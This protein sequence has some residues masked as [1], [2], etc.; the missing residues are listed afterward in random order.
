[1]EDKKVKAGSVAIGICLF[2][3]AILLVL[4]VIVFYN[5]TM[6]KNN[7]QAKVSELETTIEENGIQSSIS[8]NNS[9]DK[10]KIPSVYTAD[11]KNLSKGV[12]YDLGIGD[13][14]F[15]ISTR[16]NKITFTFSKDEKELKQLAKSLG[17]AEKDLKVE[18]H[19]GIEVTGFSKKVADVEIGC[20]GQD[21]T[22]ATFIF[23]MEDGTVEYSDVKNMLTN[24]RTQ[25]KIDGLKDI[26]RVQNVDVWAPEDGGHVSMIAIDTDNVCYD[27]SDYIKQGKDEDKNIAKITEKDIIGTFYPME[28]WPGDTP[29]IIIEENG[30]I[31]LCGNAT[32]YG[33]YE[34][35]GNEVNVVYSLREGP[36]DN[37]E[38][39]ENRKEKIT[40]INENVIK[41]TAIINNETYNGTYVRKEICK[42]IEEKAKKCID[43]QDV[44]KV[45]YMGI[46]QINE[47]NC[48]FGAYLDSKFSYIVFDTS[49]S[50]MYKI[51]EVKDEI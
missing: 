43:N 13:E 3:I 16:K 15:H 37:E 44:L 38:V 8:E 47:D 7:L 14:Y 21:V 50:N 46:Y 10:L 51:S 20:M 19:K 18:P 26:V 6:E 23:L 27:I 36:E 35:D 5:A 49:D 41:T 32:E 4:I 30:K 33:S 48:I 22:L 2:V 25:G 24:V 31:Q 11:T 1:M 45:D 29:Y 17:I 9:D 28:S 34:I 39:T 42:E 12:N 40:V